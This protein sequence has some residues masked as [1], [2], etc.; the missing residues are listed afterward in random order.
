MVGCGKRARTFPERDLC[1]FLK[2]CHTQY[3]CNLAMLL[4]QAMSLE[5]NLARV[6]PAGVGIP[7]FISSTT[8]TNVFDRR[9]LWHARR[10]WDSTLRLLL[11]VFSDNRI[12]EAAES[13]V[14]TF[15]V[16][17][18]VPVASFPV[19]A[20]PN[21]WRQRLVASARL[22]DGS[23]FKAELPDVSN[24]VRDGHMVPGV[25][26]NL[27]DVSVDERLHHLHGDIFSA[28]V[29]RYIHKLGRSSLLL[30]LLCLRRKIIEQSAR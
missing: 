19:F 5:R 13:A 29:E 16:C 12:L 22:V 25:E 24:D 8:I 3:M 20:L 14:L 23:F 15:T 4:C 26:F 28:R 10:A 6:I 2:K 11:G 21:T 30:R 27:K 17:D 7:L 1:L 18:N 9:R